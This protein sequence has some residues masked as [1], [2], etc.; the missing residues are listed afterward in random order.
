MSANLASAAFRYALRGLAVFPL[1]PGAKV[2]LSGSHGCN[3]ASPDPD[4]ARAR[5]RKWRRSNIAAATGSQ[6]GF[7]VLDVDA[8]HDGDKT[9]A[10]L[11]A[12]HGPLPLTI[13]ASTPR[14]G[15]HLYWRWPASGPEIRNSCGRVGPG[16]DVRGEGGSIVL[17]PSVLADGRC[18]RWAKNGARAIAE[19]PP[20]LI[21]AALPPPPPPRVAPKPLTGDVAAYVASAAAAE[22]AD[23]EAAPEGGRNEA[24]NRASFNLAQFVKAGALPEDWTR[25]HLE[26]RAIAIG[27]P[28]PEARRTIDS[29]FKAAQPRSLQQ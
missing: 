19:A 2:P 1:S 25:G 16:I 27:L 13:E 4:V 14:S 10:G 8:H 18:Y 21:E 26:E 3:D 9:I 5:W 29:A 15:R 28:V 11:E 17:P 20:W 22:L 6:S 23:L 12:N 24:L 7:W